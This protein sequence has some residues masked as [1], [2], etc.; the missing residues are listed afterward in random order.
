MIE[1]LAGFFL[2]PLVDQALKLLLRRAIG[3]ESISLGRLGSLRIVKA[4]I[5]WA[6]AQRSPSLA[7]M[8]AVWLL[9]ACSLVIMTI[10]AP[11]WGWCAGLILG[12]SLSHLLETSFQN[13]VTDYVCLRFWPSFNLADVAITVG[14]LGFGVGV[15]TKMKE[16]FL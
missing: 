11:S 4:R 10:P 14:A 12:G 13:F 15:A 2:I 9:A 16:F 3:P 8:W 1:M 7:V 6:R 5:W